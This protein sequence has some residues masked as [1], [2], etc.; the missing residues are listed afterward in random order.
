MMRTNK[1]SGGPL[2]KEE[3]RE[4][5]L[6][7]LEYRAH[8]RDELLQKLRRFTDAETASA[9]LDELVEVGLINDEA[10][11]VQ[12]AHDLMEEKL[13]GPIRLRQ[14][15]GR[16][17]I[18]DE[19]AEDAIWQ[20]ETEL[21]DAESRL[22]RLIGM[23]YKENLADEK[24]RRRVVNALFRLGY[25]YDMIKTAMKKAGQEMQMEW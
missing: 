17:G 2:T 18:D 15:L 4:K 8:S 13:L 3:T 9:V 22:D 12:Y 21:G 10:F 19:T 23:K 5:A 16:K 7:L 24:N 11:A 14:E 20:A 6:N 1:P 25:G